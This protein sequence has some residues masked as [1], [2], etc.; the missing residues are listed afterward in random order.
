MKILAIRI[1]NLASIEGLTEIDF[2]RE[3]LCSAGIFA[4]TGPTG[5]GKSTILDALCLALYA[6]TPRY[7]QAK[8]T[9]VTI[10]DI[11]GILI[12]QGDVRGILRD[13]TGDGFAEVDF[14][15]V[16]GTRYR[17]KWSV[18]RAR[19]KVDGA[20]QNEALS[21]LNI[22]TGI[23]LASKKTEACREIE[24]LVGLNF[25][26]FTRS[27]L[28]A[29]GDFTAFLKADKDEKASLLEKLT[30]THIYSEISRQVFIRCKEAENIVQEI[31]HQLNSVNILTE[32]QLAEFNERKT[33]LEKELSEYD[34]SISIITAGINWHERLV[35]LESARQQAIVSLNKA[36]GDREHAPGR[37]EK[38]SLIEQVQKIRT[39]V[40]SFNATKKKSENDQLALK[41]ALQDVEE[42]HNKL[43]DIDRSIIEAQ[44]RLQKNKENKESSVPLVNKA[45]ELDVRISEKLE[46]L[47]HSFYEVELSN[48]KYQEQ[49]NELI[50]KQN[51]LKKLNE[52]L[53]GLDKWKQDNK[54]R[55]PIADNLSLIKSKLIQ[56]KKLLDNIESIKKQR[57]H[58]E[59]KN[60]DSVKLTGQLQE[61]HDKAFA[62]IELLRSKCAELEE[63]L[64]TVSIENLE[65]ERSLSDSLLEELLAA[66]SH[67]IILYADKKKHRAVESKLLQEKTALS[68]ELEKLAETKQGLSS[69]TEKKISSEIRLNRARLQVAEDVEELR[70]SLV[71]GEECPVCGSLHH[72]Y[73]IDQPHANGIIQMLADEY[74]EDQLVFDHLYSEHAALHSS[75][76]L[77]E[78]SIIQLEKESKEL[79]KKI[80]EQ[81]DNWKKFLINKP[82]NA[83]S[84]NEVA[85]W[86]QKK[87]AST[88]ERQKELIEC[89]EGH[90]NNKNI[91]DENRKSLFRSELVLNDLKFQLDSE[92]KTVSSTNEKIKELDIQ[93]DFQNQ[94]L[95]DIIDHLDPFFANKTWLDNWKSSPVQFLELITEFEKTWKNNIKQLESGTIL[96]RN[97]EKEIEYL[98]SQER[99]CNLEKINKLG[100]YD[101]INS[102]KENLIQQ[103]HQIFNGEPIIEIEQQ[104]QHALNEAQELLDTIRNAKQVTGNQFAA[105]NERVGQ[106]KKAIDIDTQ[107]LISL[108]TYIN[109]WIKAFNENNSTQLDAESVNQL[110]E[111]SHDWIQSE[112]NA[113]KKI[114]DAITQANSILQ[115]RGQQLDEHLKN[116]LIENTLEE[117]L[118][119]RQF[120]IK[121]RAEASREEMEIGFKLKQDSE[122]KRKAGKLLELIKEKQVISENWS[123]LNEMIGS[124]DGKKFRQVA[125]EYTLDVLLGYANIHLNGLT[126]RYQVQ[127]IPYTLSLQV[128]DKDMG[129]EVRTVYSLSGGES[130]LV[131]LALALGLASL[132][133]SRMKVESLFIDEGFGSL[134]PTT[135][136][137]AMDALERL[138]NQGRKVGVISHVQ[139][140]TERIPTQIRVTKLSSGKSK[141]EIDGNLKI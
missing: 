112:R 101:K 114:D 35:Q 28:L 116:K 102:E 80:I 2:T 79:H 135:L 109:N 34:G 8:E 93:K 62:S 37:F 98:G 54:E 29:Q 23:V 13:G 42:L 27:V 100:I 81:E 63:K 108:T 85:G 61:Q 26:Q 83:L 134:D 17:A 87:I 14:I 74:K 41:T 5:A 51:A 75:C 9:G 136:N 39:E 18:N 68:I 43:S 89:I 110:L 111:Y 20:M 21:I 65:T 50:N 103:R 90:R 69:A 82:C 141:I 130:F 131:S 127:R 59:N 53:T 70:A 140:M 10:Q 119:S 57:V 123:R 106:L 45:K 52:E 71:N 4:I 47:Q 44:T 78:K 132:S 24:R 129:D 60:A 86:I 55:E 126:K 58:C 67:W 95:K 11:P 3:P 117:L 30:G 84:E 133:S 32:E 113:L 40:D 66:Q 38:L 16:D 88:K 99:S 118:E 31:K 7:L 96:L 125:Q 1:K 72:P 104:L 137:I 46:Q 139:E 97:L 107:H 56:A 94:E 19:G 124:A 22:E 138:H 76:S 33:I 91:L 49:A 36:H 105:A 48:K 92:N 73:T 15:G 25:E 64:N 6:K 121:K 120:I 77:T 12:N 115:E 128:L 122:N